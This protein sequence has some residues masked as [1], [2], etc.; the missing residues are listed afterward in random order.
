[1]YYSPLESQKAIEIS[2]WDFFALKETTS[3]PLGAISSPLRIYSL[4]AGGQSSGRLRKRRCQTGEVRTLESTKE[5]PLRPCP[6][7]SVA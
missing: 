5:A 7:L 2:K 6:R 1:M 3:T 4:V